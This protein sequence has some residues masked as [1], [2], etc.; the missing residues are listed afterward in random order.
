M[1]YKL[2][3]GE[4]PG[5]VTIGIGCFQIN[6]IEIPQLIDGIPLGVSIPHGNDFARITL[7]LVHGVDGS[8]VII[9]VVQTGHLSHQ[10]DGTSRYGDDL[11]PFVLM[12]LDSVS[13]EKIVSKSHIPHHIMND[14]FNEAVMKSFDGQSID[15]GHF[16]EIVIIRTYSAVILVVVGFHLG[17][18]VLFLDDLTL[19]HSLEKFLHEHFSVKCSIDIKKSCCFH[20][21][22]LLLF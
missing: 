8:S 4:I 14:V 3:H 13:G 6:V 5:G 11:M 12:P 7:L 15:I 19:D 17:K 21:S 9:K 1:P 18:P 2:E 22:I 16:D 10:F 20:E